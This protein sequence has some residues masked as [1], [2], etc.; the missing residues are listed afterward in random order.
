MRPKDTIE[1]HGKFTFY[2]RFNFMIVHISR[3]GE[4]HQSILLVSGNRAVRATHPETNNIGAA[5][6]GR[7]RGSNRGARK[8]EARRH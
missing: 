4:G 6:K 3:E 1:S 7:S 2:T 5:R 8:T